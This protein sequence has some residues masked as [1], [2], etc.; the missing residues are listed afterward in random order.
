MFQLLVG[1]Y[2]KENAVSNM[3][4]NFFSMRVYY[5]TFE[6]KR[7]SVGKPTSAQL[8]L[9]VA[10]SLCAPQL[11]LERKGTLLLS[12]LLLEGGEDRGLGSR[13]DGRPDRQV[14]LCGGGQWGI[15]IYFC[16]VSPSSL[17]KPKKSTSFEMM[18]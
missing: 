8:G 2:K 15:V 4:D 3:N 16:S 17:V 18:A 7:C 6:Q 14:S 5:T 1:I 12:V 11:D 10:D 9:D 13:K